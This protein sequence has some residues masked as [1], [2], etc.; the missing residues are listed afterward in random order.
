MTVDG[1]RLFTIKKQ[2]DGLEEKI[3]IDD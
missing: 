1:P 2:I 3:W